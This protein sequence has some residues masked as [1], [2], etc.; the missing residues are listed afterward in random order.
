VAQELVHEWN[1]ELQLVR[2]V[3]GLPRPDAA[4]SHVAVYPVRYESE[5]VAARDDVETVARTQ[6]GEVSTCICTGGV[7]ERL[8]EV[9][10]EQSVTD[11]V[12]ASHG[13][14][15]LSRVV[16]GSVADDLVQ[17]LH[18]SI[19]VIPAHAARAVEIED[20]PARIIP[21]AAARRGERESVGV[22]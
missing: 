5:L 17:H 6:Q 10:E 4:Y 2:V 8:T 16:L 19:L 20:G 14:T 1:A 3:P 22:R 9:V 21:L 12:M 13:R 11:I 15:G 18:C 7:V